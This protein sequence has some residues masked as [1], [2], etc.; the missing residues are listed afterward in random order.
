MRNYIF[1][2]LDWMDTCPAPGL[3]CATN[4][5]T[6]GVEKWFFYKSYR[7]VVNVATDGYM[8]ISLFTDPDVGTPLNCL[9]ETYRRRSLDNPLPVTCNADGTFE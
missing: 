7:D 2:V 1:E 3:G 9:G 5:E 8:G 4:A 6:Y